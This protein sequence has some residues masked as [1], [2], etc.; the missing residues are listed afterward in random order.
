M[1][2]LE[3]KTSA[4]AAFIPKNGDAL[5]AAE[6]LRFTL[7]STVD[8]STPLDV[9]VLDLHISLLYY[10]VAFV[11]P[12]GIADGEYKY[13]LTSGPSLLSSGLVMVGSTFAPDIEYDKTIEYEQY[14]S[15]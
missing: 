10:D 8:L 4:Q 2:Y 15:E 13:E 12:E 5:A 9:T 3:N 14:E 1:I 6:T 11:L 7:R